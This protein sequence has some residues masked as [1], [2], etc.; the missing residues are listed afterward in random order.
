M[1]V[2]VLLFSWDVYRVDAHYLLP[3]KEW[4][5]YRASSLFPA[6]SDHTMKHIATVEAPNEKQAIAKAQ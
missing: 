1:R 6:F 3:G 5:A 4:L 2:E